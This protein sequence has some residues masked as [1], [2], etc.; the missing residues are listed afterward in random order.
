M[1]S[2]L[3]IN[4]FMTFISESQEGRGPGIDPSFRKAPTQAMFPCRLEE[5]LERIHESSQLDPDFYPVK[6]RK[7]LIFSYHLH[8]GSFGGSN[9]KDIHRYTCKG[10]Q[11]LK[12]F[13][14]VSTAWDQSVHKASLCEVLFPFLENPPSPGRTFSSSLLFHAPPLPQCFLVFWQHSNLVLPH[15]LC[16]CWVTS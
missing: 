14:D 1:V 15:D 6:T 2:M 5:S 9:K 8:V 3:L 12:G 10:P 16:I 13:A 4:C 7:L 11:I